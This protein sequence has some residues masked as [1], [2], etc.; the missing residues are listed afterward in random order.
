MTRGLA[1]FAECGPQ[2]ADE[3]AS[4]CDDDLVDVFA[5]SLETRVP[6]R[7]PPL[8]FLRNREHTL[9]LA[10]ATFPKPDADGRTMAVLPAR[11]YER[12]TDVA[13]TRLGDLAVTSAVTTRMQ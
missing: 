10:L 8:R 12:A 2:E 1:L 4:D 5:A 11:L 6:T 9:G 13:V 3:L 7:Q